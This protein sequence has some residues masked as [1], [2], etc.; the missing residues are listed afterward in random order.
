MGSPV[1][2]WEL[3]INYLGLL[4]G[5]FGTPPPP[6]I[7]LWG[8]M[9]GGGRGGEDL[10]DT[11]GVFLGRPQPHDDG[12]GVSFTVTA[13]AAVVFHISCKASSPKTVSR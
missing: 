1:W 12:Y 10:G 2:L 8:I 13:D 5:C 6:P 3:F 7:H 9:G 11:D 4:M